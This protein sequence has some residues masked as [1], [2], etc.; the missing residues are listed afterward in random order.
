MPYSNTAMTGEIHEYINP[1]S[2]TI[3]SVLIIYRDGY[4]YRE[5]DKV[6]RKEDVELNV[7]YQFLCL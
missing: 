5:L 3:I 2:I 4:N 1:Y 6:I 7:S